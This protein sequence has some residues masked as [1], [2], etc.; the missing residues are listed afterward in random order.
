[1]KDKIIFFLIILALVALCVFSIINMFGGFEVIEHFGG[2]SLAIGI[3]KIPFAI[4]GGLQFLR[5]AFMLIAK[6][7][8][9]IEEYA[10]QRF[11]YV[12]LVAD[13][14]ISILGVYFLLQ[15]WSVQ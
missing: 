11:R 6:D 3:L 13:I 12:A 4:W 2:G 7:S 5:A 10:E 14:V 8:Q 15:Y 1:M 9:Y